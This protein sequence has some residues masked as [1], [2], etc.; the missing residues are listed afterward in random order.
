M[1]CCEPKS[2]NQQKKSQKA[3]KSD[4]AACGVRHE[5]AEPAPTAKPDARERKGAHPATR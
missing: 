5:H 3:A 1:S 2:T 4:H